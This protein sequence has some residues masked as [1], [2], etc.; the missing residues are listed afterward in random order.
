MS[1]HVPLIFGRITQFEPN[2][3]EVKMFKGSTEL[4]DEAQ[5]LNKAIMDMR[6]HEFWENPYLQPF[7]ELFF[8]HTI[9]VAPFPQ[10]EGCLGLRPKDSQISISDGVAAMSFDYKVD[11]S[12]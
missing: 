10:V 2:V 12:N 1:E 7:L 4:R 8:G 9:P 3:H 6:T 5:S 11:K